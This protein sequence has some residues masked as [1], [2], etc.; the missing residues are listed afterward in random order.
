MDSY[1]LNLAGVEVSMSLHLA[2]RPLTAVELVPYLAAKRRDRV[3]I[4]ARIRAVVTCLSLSLL[5]YTL[6]LAR[7]RRRDG[8]RLLFVHPHDGR[9]ARQGQKTDR[10]MALVGVVT[11]VRKSL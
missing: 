9:H 3:L 2:G 11:D 4:L 6:G 5:F 10:R 7:G 8:S 1:V